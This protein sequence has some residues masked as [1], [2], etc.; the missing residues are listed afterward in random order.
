[1]RPDK[2]ARNVSDLS[3][4][5]IAKEL[6]AQPAMTIGDLYDDP[7]VQLRIAKIIDL[8]TYR[9]RAGKSAVQQHRKSVVAS[10]Y[11]LPNGNTIGHFQF[12]GRRA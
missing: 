9:K 3:A 5:E 1:M 4:D 11:A 2:A 8:A 7:D 12:Y 6:F 10:D